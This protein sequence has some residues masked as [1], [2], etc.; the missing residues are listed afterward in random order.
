MGCDYA[1]AMEEGMTPNDAGGVSFAIS[2]METFRRFLILG[3]ESSMYVASSTLESLTCSCIELLLHQGY[4]E[5]MLQEIAR[6]SLQ[7]LAPK[8]T[9]A[10]FALARMASI[11]VEARRKIFRT[12]LPV[13]CR[14]FSTLT[15]FLRFIPH[16]SWG[17][18]VRK[19]VQEWLLHFSPQ[20][21][22]YQFTKYRNRH[23]YTPK[24]LLRLVHPKPV[25]GYEEVFAYAAGKWD[26][27]YPSSSVLHDYLVAAYVV[28]HSQDVHAVIPLIEAY[29]FGWE[30]VGQQQLLR[31]ARVWNAF[32]QNGM[33]YQALL[34]N[35]VRMLTLQLSPYM[36]DRTT[37]LERLTNKEAIRKSRTH[38]IQVLQALRMVGSATQD[39]EV[40]VALQLAFHESF[41]NIPP[42][43]QRLLLAVDVSGSMSSA[44]CVGMRELSALDAATAIALTMMKQEPYVL[45]LAFSEGLTPLPVKK[46]MTLC[47]AL[48]SMKGLP[49]QRTDCSLPMEY[50]L[51][52]KILVDCFVVITDNETNYNLRHPHVVLQEYREKV[53]P[54]AKLVVLATSACNVSIADPTDKGMLDMAGMD[55]SIFHVLY[56][57]CNRGI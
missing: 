20:D 38:P 13:V 39:A 10:L 8:Q 29:H 57:F 14:T 46:D 28:R 22:A 4:M 11:S 45:A 54:N 34:R 9:Y 48:E 25:A 47:E 12:M 56:Q 44:R 26:V 31:D 50:A 55:S 40:E 52:N 41:H 21:L 23:G 51:A 42:T 7:G 37:L 27:N 3:S 36:L 5:D 33:P 15:E 49:F 24:D 1:S 6:V 18:G 2:D 16:M 17:H 53:N 32:L 30:H 19:G 35:V 43:Y